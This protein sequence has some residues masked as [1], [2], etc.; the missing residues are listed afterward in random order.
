MDHEAG[1]TLRPLPRSLHE[2]GP[3]STSDP[4]L[5]LRN[6]E[7]TFLWS[8]GRSS[9]FSD[10]EAK[11]FGF[12]HPMEKLMT[13]LKLLSAGLLAAAMLTTP[14][15]AREYRAHARY[16]ADNANTSVQQPTFYGDGERCIPAPRVGAFATQPWD[17]AAPCEPASG[18]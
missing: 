5:V 16:G 3:P 12:L 8:T 9:H 4:L 7:K 2:A 13:Q 14:A 10:S 17:K 6:R 11:H 1:G 15:L 18:Y